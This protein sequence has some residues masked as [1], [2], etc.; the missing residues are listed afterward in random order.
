MPG[1]NRILVDH[2]EKAAITRGLT[3]L[4]E[5][6]VIPWT[7][8]IR[9]SRANERWTI[10]LSAP[11]HFWAGTAGLGEQNA[12]SIVALVRNA[13]RGDLAGARAYNQE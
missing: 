5:T 6:E 12:P 13:L 3:D 9:P 11:G 4:F 7:V 10:E 1:S 2:V 8:T